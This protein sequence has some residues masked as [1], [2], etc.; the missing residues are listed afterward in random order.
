MVGLVY[1]THWKCHKMGVNFWPCSFGLLHKLWD[2]FV[3]LIKVTSN[4]RVTLI[5][6]SWKFTSKRYFFPKKKI[7][8][9]MKKT[10]NVLHTWLQGFYSKLKYWKTLKIDQGNPLSQYQTN[11]GHSKSSGLRLNMN[12]LRFWWNFSR[13]KLYMT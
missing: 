8:E 4:Y 10:L 2:D 9:A 1:V 12:Y 6:L 7:Q 5:D 3:R 11:E 13:W